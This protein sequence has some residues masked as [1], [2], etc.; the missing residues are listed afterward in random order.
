MAYINLGQVIYPIGAIYASANSTSP[1][2]LFGG[3]W[4]QITN[5]ALRGATS[6]GY[7]GSDTHQ[8][9]I[10]EMPSHRHVFSHWYYGAAGTNSP[11]PCNYANTINKPGTEAGA[12]VGGGSTYQCATLL[13]LLYVATYKLNPQEVM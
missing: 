12:S 4:T 11:V 5:A 8:L 10:Q 7:T 9:T 3:S 13:Q 1:A 6:V 2:S